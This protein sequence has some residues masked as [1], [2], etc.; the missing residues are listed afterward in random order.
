M[1]YMS[2]C[3]ECPQR[4]CWKFGS[5]KDSKVAEAQCKVVKVFEA[6]F[7]KGFNASLPEFGLLRPSSEERTRVEWRMS[8]TLTFRRLRQWDHH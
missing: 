7:S 6:L 3:S 1:L 2:L 5:Q 8:L 4:V